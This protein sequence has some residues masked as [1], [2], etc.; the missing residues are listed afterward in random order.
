[1]HTDL[2]WHADFKKSTAIMGTWAR[3]REDLSF[4]STW[5]A[6]LQYFGINKVAG[7]AWE[8]IPCSFMID[9]VFGA[10]AYINKLRFRTETPFNEF[11][12]MWH[13]IKQET[14][15]KLYCIPGW[16]SAYDDY[17]TSPSEPFVVAIRRTTNYLRYPGLPKT[18]ES[19]LDFSA[20]GLFH[21]LTSGSII[22]QNRLK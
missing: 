2:K 11:R 16:N 17:L 1:L 5:S 3:V 15:E 9:W 22:I 6:Y 7:L 12:G 8:L 21:L 20:L 4:A 18:T 13:S 14:S 19:A 10:Q